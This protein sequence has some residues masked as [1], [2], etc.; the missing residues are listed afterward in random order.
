MVSDLRANAKDSSS[1]DM[2]VAEFGVVS[3]RYFEPLKNYH[4]R[5]YRM[6][7]EVQKSVCETMGFSAKF[8]LPAIRTAYMDVFR[9][10]GHVVFEIERNTKPGDINVRYSRDRWAVEEVAGRTAEGLRPWIRTEYRAKFADERRVKAALAELLQI[11]L[12]DS[13]NFLIRFNFRE[14]TFGLIGEEQFA[15]QFPADAFSTFDLQSSQLP[16]IGAEEIAAGKDAVAQQDFTQA[17]ISGAATNA[18]VSSMDSNR[19]ES[20]QASNTENQMN[21]ETQIETATAQIENTEAAQPTT[22]EAPAITQTPDATTVQS[23]IAPAQ[24]EAPAKQDSFFTK[25]EPSPAKQQDSF[26]NKQEPSRRPT[27]TA[28]RGERSE[29]GE[30]GER[31]ERHERTSHTTTST[32]PARTAESQQPKYAVYSMSEIDYMFKQQADQILTA[33]SSK[34]AAQ[35][36][37][38]QEAI[39]AQEKAFNRIAENFSSQFDEARIRLEGTTKSAQDTTHREME[40]FHR[41]FSKEL[42]Q[43][44]T[45]INK[46]V[47]PVAKALE[48]PSKFKQQQKETVRTEPQQQV[49]KGISGAN[50]AALQKQVQIAVIAAAASALISFAFG[51]FTVLSL[52]D[53]KA[54]HTA[55]TTTTTTTDSTQ[56]TP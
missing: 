40:E 16:D 9:T 6:T 35:Q 1:T 56:S 25:Q 36:R 13:A 2:F 11:K 38:F 53:V 10:E 44:R 3:S 4:G 20:N 39:T 42:E 8:D 43:Y 7:P 14:R 45:H 55:A 37:G 12:D 29:R 32:S 47:L 54:A 24:P 18:G 23:E 48:D 34:V 19:L 26:F 31:S 33:L 27:V 41:Q 49:A 5:L 51:V 15:D 28:E 21:T 17:T 46:V 30:R 52:A 22:P 50:V